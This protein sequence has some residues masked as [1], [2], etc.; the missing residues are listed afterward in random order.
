M[1][2]MIVGYRDQTVIPKAY[3]STT[4]FKTRS[5]LLIDNRKIQSYLEFFV[6]VN[7]MCDDLWMEA[8]FDEGT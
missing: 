7:V 5:H 1:S 6:L 2:N 3:Y 4:R 8:T